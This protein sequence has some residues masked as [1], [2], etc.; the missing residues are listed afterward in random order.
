M[1][2]T[3]SGT[4]GK[5]NFLLARVKG[6]RIHDLEPVVHVGASRIAK[7]SVDEVGAVLASGRARHGKDCRERSQGG[8]SNGG[9][10]LHCEIRLWLSRKSRVVE[11]VVVVVGFEGFDCV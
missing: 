8:K 3:L 11:R 10:E 4:S 5:A 2:L 9:E 1:V 6:L 7:S